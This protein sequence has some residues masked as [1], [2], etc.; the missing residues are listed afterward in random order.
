MDDP[1][2]RQNEAFGLVH[3]ELRRLAAAW[4][5]SRSGPDTLQPTALVH[6]ASAISGMSQLIETD[7]ARHDVKGEEWRARPEAAGPGP[8]AIDED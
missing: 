7:E 4:W 5:R 1:E 6:E 8:G 2:A 3:A